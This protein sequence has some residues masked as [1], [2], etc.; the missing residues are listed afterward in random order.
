MWTG[1]KPERE[2]KLVNL[3]ARVPG[4]DPKLENEPVLVMAHLDH[5]GRGWPDVR[6]GNENQIHPG[7]DDNASG[8]AVLLELAR[9]MAAE[10][11]RPR[12][13]LF[14]VVTGEEAGLVGSRHLLESMAMPTSCA[15]ERTNDDSP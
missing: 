5:L 9:A 8:V 3:V 13:V 2:I 10:P 11:P 1:G 12:P 7:A 6:E 14:A 15:A 4:R